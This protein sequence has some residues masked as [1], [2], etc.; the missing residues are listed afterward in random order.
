M[1]SVLWFLGNPEQVHACSCV[2]HLGQ[3]YN[4]RLAQAPL[5]MFMLALSLERRRGG[6]IPY[7]GTSHRKV[8]SGACVR[9]SERDAPHHAATL[10][11]RLRGNDVIEMRRVVSLHRRISEFGRSGN[12]GGQAS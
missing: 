7:A 1:M 4:G 5:N 9:R 3:L 2:Q 10:D 11:S 6:H 8:R 12:A